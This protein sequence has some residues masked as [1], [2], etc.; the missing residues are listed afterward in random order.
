MSTISSPAGGR[1]D[2]QYTPYTINEELS[3]HYNIANE[4][5]KH[6]PVVV[7]LLFHIKA[8]LNTH[9]STKPT[10]TTLHS[11]NCL[12]LWK[13]YVTV[14]LSCISLID[15]FPFVS[16]LSFTHFHSISSSSS[17]WLHPRTVGGD[18]FDPRG[19]HQSFLFMVYSFVRETSR[20]YALDVDVFNF[21]K[22]T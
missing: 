2:K 10:A 13:F 15:A 11:T 12:Q 21:L 8:W 3:E 9:P 7:C 16:T 22:F 18:G 4:K 20:Q 1:I 14:K 5:V 17:L 6:C 19:Q